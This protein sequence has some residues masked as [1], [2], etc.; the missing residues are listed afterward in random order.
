M[1]NTAYV[2]HPLPPAHAACSRMAP[3]DS[4]KRK[5]SSV[6][7]EVSQLSTGHRML[8]SKG[9]PQVIQK[10]VGGGQDFTDHINAMAKRGL[11]TLGV[12]LVARDDEDRLRRERRGDV[13]GRRS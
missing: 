9:A 6:V 2:T 5:M 4:S 12:H 10:L 11:R 7:A 13:P 8:V 3:V 1:S